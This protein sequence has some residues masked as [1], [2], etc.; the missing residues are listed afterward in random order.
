ML[1]AWLSNLVVNICVV[2][3]KGHAREKQ[4]CLIGAQWH[5]MATHI[6]INIGSAIGLLHDSTKPLPEPMSANC[7]WG[8]RLGSILQII[9]KITMID[10]S[11]KITNLKLQPYLPGS[12]QLMSWQEGYSSQTNG[13][14]MVYSNI[15]SM[16]WEGKRNRY[17]NEVMGYILALWSTYCFTGNKPH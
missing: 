10:W 1:I 2:M 11:M 17:I 12:N 5:H 6:W 15:P 9:F 8:I 13:P 3:I 4:F 7:H 16:W 14:I